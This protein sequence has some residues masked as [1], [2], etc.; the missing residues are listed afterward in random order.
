VFDSASSSEYSSADIAEELAAVEAELRRRAWLQA[1][2][3]W[4]KERL[5]EFV[6]SKQKAILRS[7]AENRRT[8]VH[9][10]HEAGKSFIASRIA[11]WW[12]DS[13]PPGT[14]FVVTSAAT[15][16]QVK[17]I[18]WREIG[19]MHTKGGLAGR[20]NQSEWF[21]TIVQPN[22][23][24]KEE[25]VAVG[26]KP[27]EYNPAAFQGI[28]ARYVLVIFDEA[29][30]IPGGSSDKPHS[31]WEAAD[32]LIAN[33]DSRFLA[34]GNPDDPQSEFAEVCKPGSGWNVIGIDALDTPNFT[35]EYV[36]DDLRFLL[37]GKTW[38]E[39][40]KR[41]WGEDNPLYVSKIRGKFPSR[42][43]DGLIPIVW[44]IAAQKR[45]LEPGFPD[46]LGVDVGAGGDKNTVAR[47]RGPVVRIIRRDQEPDTMK[48]CGNL[49]ADLAS[50]GSSRAKVDK[51]G[52]GTGMVDR[53]IEQEA[54]VVGVNVG[55]AA[56]DEKQYENVRAEGYWLLRER[57]QDGEI[58]IDPKD[59][60]L[61]AQLVD[62]KFKRSSRGR[63]V[64][65]SKEE[66]KRRGR[67]SP[68]DADAVMLAFLPDE[69]LGPG[70]V[71]EL[72]V[73]WG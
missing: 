41:R 8:A 3:D 70:A 49:I 66:M 1:P 11:G 25:L 18:L 58:D 30:G 22:G 48:S 27:S 55:R 10:C 61:A 37:I 38:V 21:M 15:G 14:A 33:D 68:D 42:T 7:V 56:R 5:G 24:A 39:E 23:N 40:K 13:H 69:L 44:V 72:G 65:E 32:S 31:L 17:A 73:L 57:F 35:G 12:L 47:R 71:Q 67:P 29:C 60:D 16:D 28:H 45:V 26:R 63:I 4:V 59:D 62:L 34:I 2:E 51:I 54:P 50:T 46:E 19:R 20:V 52:V 9:S 6:W 53:A 43:V 36:P 64:I